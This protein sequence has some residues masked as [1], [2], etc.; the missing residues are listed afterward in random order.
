MRECMTAT[1]SPKRPRKRATVW[2]VREISGTSTMARRPSASVR[3][4]ACRYTSVL[5]EPVTPSTSTTRPSP[6]ARAASMAA[7]AAFWPSVSCGAAE[8]AGAAAP[9]VGAPARE[10][11]SS[12]P[13]M[14]RRRSTVTAPLAA[15]A[16]NVEPTAPNSRDSSATRTSPAPTAASIS[17]CFTAFLRGTNASKAGPRVTQRSSTSPMAGSSTRQR[18]S[19]PRTMRGTARGGVNK[20]AHSESGAA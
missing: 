6:A 18:P 7:T 19:R 14:R 3:S 15:S 17:C 11:P 12:M 13:R 4:M 20:R 8:G 1:A 10:A 5:P 9:P 2:G 16:F